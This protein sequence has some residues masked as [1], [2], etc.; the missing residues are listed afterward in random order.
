MRKYSRT[1]FNI[2]RIS[3]VRSKQTRE[4]VKLIL[5]FKTEGQL[6]EIGCGDGKLL[7]KLRKTFKV[8]AIDISSAAIRKARK[9]LPGERN[10]KVLDIEKEDLEGQH[11][12]IICLNVLEHLKNPEAAIL[13]IRESL[14]NDG[15]FIFSVPN[16]YSL[17]RVSTLI[18]NTFDR[19]H[20]STYKRDQWVELV[21]RCGLEPVQIRNGFL[22]KPFTRQFTR[23]FATTMFMI[24]RK[25]KS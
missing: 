3:L 10:L 20:I 13:K 7:S 19:T 12:V 1:Y 8:M 24:T 16:N 4:L 9:R 25:S 15:V 18:M 11:D 2:H 6:L 17:G 21:R 5:D 14:K 22:Y 23:H